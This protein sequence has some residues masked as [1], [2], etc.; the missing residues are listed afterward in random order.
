ML[1]DASASSSQGQI[2]ACSLLLPLLLL[3]EQSVMAEESMENARTIKDGGGEGGRESAR[4]CIYTK[5][6]MNCEFVQL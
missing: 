5:G 2:Q 4:T 3:S 1:H 6:I